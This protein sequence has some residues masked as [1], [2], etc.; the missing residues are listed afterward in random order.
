MYS[1]GPSQSQD[2]IDQD[3]EDYLLGKRKI[4]AS[5]FKTMSG[6]EMVLFYIL[7]HSYTSIGGIFYSLYNL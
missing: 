3:K 5:T 2:F 4:D 6:K 7:A 1:A